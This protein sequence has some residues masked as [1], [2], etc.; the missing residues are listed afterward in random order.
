MGLHL[1]TWKK[2]KILK[3]YSMRASGQPE[4]NRNLLEFNRIMLLLSNSQY[5]WRTWDLSSIWTKDLA[6]SA[7]SKSTKKGFKMKANFPI[8]IT[9]SK[10]IFY[11]CASQ[12]IVNA[13]T[14]SVSFYIVRDN[15]SPALFWGENYLREI[16]SS[17]QSFQ[18]TFTFVTLQKD[19]V[20]SSCGLLIACM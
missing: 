14:A 4:V 2:I 11:L 17:A 9:I 7:S 1:Q 5:S 12:R 19:S 15:T 3:W 6:E 13:C 20:K 8:K 10:E 18:I 16:F